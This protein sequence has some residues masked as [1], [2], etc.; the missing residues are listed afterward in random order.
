MHKP[1]GYCT[2]IEHRKNDAA[3]TARKYQPMKQHTAFFRSIL[4]SVPDYQPGKPP[5]TVPGLQ[6]YKLS[7]NEHFLEPIPAVQE[8]LAKPVS[9]A[10]YPDAAADALVQ[11]LVNYL[12]VPN[13]HIAIGAGGSELLTA[14]AQV[15]LEAGTEVVYPWPSFEMYPQ[16]SA[17]NA[18]DQKPI[19]L[20]ADS[21]HDL[22]A[23]IEAIT[24][25]TRLVL[26]CSPNNPTGPSLLV[27]EF[28]EF[29]AQVPS[30]VL[31]VLDEAYWEFNTAPDAVDG[32]TA[33]KNHENLVLVRTFSKA[34][35]LAGLRVG[36][37]V[38]QPEVTAAIGK[39]IIP[40]GVTQASQDAA[41]A[42][43]HHV[44]DVMERARAI[45]TARDNFAHALRTQG[46]DV[47]EAQANFVWLALQDLST[48]FEDACVEQSLAVRNLTDGVRISIGPAEAMDRML[49]V[50]QQFRER[51]F[52]SNRF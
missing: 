18:A 24:P 27:T 6:P 11:E 30:E 9:P 10:L 32:L 26:L 46:W 15:T 52:P 36:Y 42:S 49:K 3:I 5:A 40:F 33:L 29:M 38:A 4:D 19:G 22:P 13:D 37:T 39:A 31:V 50:T 35:G 12:Q 7:S 41:V 51:H 2:K 47:P 1:G 34:H 17:L 20:T 43:L 8:S 25:R 28:E 21:R 48:V 16:I 45:A 14:I 44:D 23:I